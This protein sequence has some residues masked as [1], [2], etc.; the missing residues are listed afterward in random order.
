MAQ[1]QDAGVKLRTLFIKVGIGLVSISARCDQS[2]R[3]VA[4]PSHLPL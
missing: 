4:I 2:M 1:L 3:D